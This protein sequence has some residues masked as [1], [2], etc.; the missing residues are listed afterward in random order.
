MFMLKSGSNLN[1]VPDIG[2][3]LTQWQIHDDTRTSDA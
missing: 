1:T 3:K 2:G